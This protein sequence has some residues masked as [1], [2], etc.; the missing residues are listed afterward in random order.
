MTFEVKIEEVER[1]HGLYI[2]PS[3]SYLYHDDRIEYLSIYGPNFIVLDDGDI[4]FTK[5]VKVEMYCRKGDKLYHIAFDIPHT[6][7]ELNEVFEKTKKIIDTKTMLKIL[8]KLE[9]IGKNIDP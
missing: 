8:E 3:L 4:T 5:S 6:L 2:V 1:T 7:E 9:I